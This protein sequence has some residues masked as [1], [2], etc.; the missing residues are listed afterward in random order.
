MRAALRMWAMFLVWAGALPGPTPMAGFPD[1]YAALTMGPPP[2]AITTATWGERIKVSTSG[3]LGL[4]M[5]WMSPGGA[6]AACAAASSFLAASLQ[7]RLAAGCGLITMALRLSS[8][9]MTL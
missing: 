7:H 3:M 1:E 8:A 2:V 4:S 9:S 6:P 5:H